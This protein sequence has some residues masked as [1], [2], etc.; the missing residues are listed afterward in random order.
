MFTVSRQDSFCRNRDGHQVPQVCRDAESLE[1]DGSTELIN[2]QAMRISAAGVGFFISMLNRRKIAPY[3][4]H[5][6]AV[7]PM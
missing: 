1:N 7:I 3:P 6:S 2:S 4:M 5:A